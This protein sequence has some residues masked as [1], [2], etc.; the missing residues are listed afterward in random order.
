MKRGYLQARRARP[1]VVRS[2][3]AN[4]RAWIT[5]HPAGRTLAARAQNPEAALIRGFI[6]KQSNED[7]ARSREFITIT[8]KF[9]L[10]GCFTQVVCR[11]SR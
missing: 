3:N 8:A 7:G 1:S 9:P 6:L 10:R 5:V 2:S 4:G 11:G